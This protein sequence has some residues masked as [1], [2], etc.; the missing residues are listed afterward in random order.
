MQKQNESLKESQSKLMEKLQKKLS[1]SR[2]SN[3]IETFTVVKDISN[4]ILED[5]AHS[6]NFIS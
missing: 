4:F 2:Q 5:M 1:E 6:K 3:D